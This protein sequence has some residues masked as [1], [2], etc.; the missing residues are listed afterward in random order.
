MKR[1]IASGLTLVV[2]GWL[3]A[4]G[5]GSTGKTG[6]SSLAS[7]T[8]ASAEQCP[9]GG[10]QISVGSDKN[11]NNLLEEGEITASWPVCNGTAGVVGTDGANSMFLS[12]PLP[13]SEDCPFG[14]VELLTWI[15]DGDGVL[16]EAERASSVT[17]VLCSTQA[18][19]F[20][21]LVFTAPVSFAVS[22]ELYKVNPDG[23]APVKLAATTDATQTI[24]SFKVSPDK[25]M[26]AFRAQMESS[27]VA[28]LYIAS[29]V[30]NREIVPVS[31]GTSGVSDNFEWLPD[32]SR[33]A[34]LEG[35]SLYTVLPDGTGRIE[36]AQNAYI[37]GTD[38]IAGEPY[39]HYYNGTTGILYFA[40]P[41]GTL[42]IDISGGLAVNGYEISPDGTYASY[43]QETIA[44][45]AELG[46]F[47]SGNV[48]RR[49]ETSGTG[50]P[51]QAFVEPGSGARVVF[52]R[53]TAA[54]YVG[55][56]LASTFAP[57][58]LDTGG[59]TAGPVWW[60]APGVLIYRGED[61]NGTRNLYHLRLD[62]P[63]APVTTN[64]SNLSSGQ[65]VIHRRIAPGGA[66]IAYSVN[67]GD[68][69]YDLWAV[70]LTSFDTIRLAVGVPG[71][72]TL[73]SSMHTAAFSPDGQRFAYLTPA[74]A[75]TELHLTNADGSANTTIHTT[76]AG[77]TM[78]SVVGW[79]PDGRVTF[80]LT[81][82]D[83]R[84]L[85]VLPVT[86][87]DPLRMSPTPQAGNTGSFVWVE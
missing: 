20:S 69:T 9:N 50:S 46:G 49:C 11:R 62:G 67:N 7:V 80:S 34:Y 74:G 37:M 53:G 10:S 60:A 18:E 72:T 6:V 77:H 13:P 22:A 73:G 42:E 16:G 64:L 23:S 26:V 25:R 27:G 61:S 32:S 38:M 48:V 30:D 14:A 8:A 36:I 65:Q 29:L 47:A 75:P 12:T 63:G 39:V 40:R 15:D 79:S 33:L 76:A 56:A 45:I 31:V 43:I 17:Q 52:S 87:G 3:M 78:G 1:Y 86:G 28:E 55:D 44:C 84:G 58:S 85:F 51:S 70:S 71:D 81:G 24:S 83:D 59:I 2:V 82:P 35:S 21:G 5:G 54:I 57:Q 4:C 41:D 68:T 19:A 66:A